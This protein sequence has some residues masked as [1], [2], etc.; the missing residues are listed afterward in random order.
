VAF[1]LEDLLPN[2]QQLRTVQLHEPVTAALNVMSQHAFGQL[3]V[4]GVD[5]GFHGLVITFE[6]ILRAVQAFRIMPDRLLVRDAI[7]KVRSTYSADADL[8]ITLDDIHR[9]NFVIIADGPR[10]KG[11]VTTA[12]VAVFFRE[13]AEDLMVI[14]DIESGL[15]EAIQT[16]YA[17]GSALASAM[18][19]VT[20]RAGEIRKR[21]PAAIRG[22]LSKMGIALPDPASE[23][24]ALL[25]AEKR[26][27]LPEPIKAFESLAFNDYIEVLLAHERA[28]R[29]ST[30][31][32]VSEVRGLLQR[33]RDVRNKLAHFRGELTPEER[34]TIRFAAKWLE[35]NLL[36]PLP[37]TIKAPITP[38]TTPA[39]KEQ[40]EIDDEAIES[41][42]G[43]YELL[44]KELRRQPPE[45]SFL[46]LTFPQI[47]AILKKEL[48]RSAF[49]YRAWWSNDPL[50]PQ[51][52]AWLDEGWKTAAV[53]MTERR[54]S[55]VR[56][57]DRQKAYIKFFAGLNARLATEEG[58]PLRASSPQG[59]NWHVLASLGPSATITASFA[60]RKR[61]RVEIYL[62]YGEKYENK[63]RF[64]E[65]LDR[66]EELEERFGEP[67]EWER[68]DDKRACRI[69]V[70]TPAQILKEGEN[71]ALIEWA[72]QKAVRFN[73]V[74]KA[75]LAF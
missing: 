53:N 58:F 66:R 2:G 63:T 8:L 28:P 43:T 67:L 20:D 9:D 19:A 75:E 49:E 48:P 12:D 14:E 34:H 32:D 38:P 65:L 4:T 74:F 16:L 72:A 5:G 36:T 73:L 61:L 29:L 30:S 22:Y 1:T 64:Q 35:N 56:T 21:I 39:L 23:K 26:L 40:E 10:L 71:P 69:A 6:S 15:K 60:R 25:E 59:I 3:P 50:K 51:S 70:Y 13:Y 11:I 24:D 52:T 62:D 44:A 68:M 17:D 27:G 33:V 47:G 31:Q 18:S 37:E 55:F 54:L 57:D 41:P 46:T 7:Q 42:V 45:T